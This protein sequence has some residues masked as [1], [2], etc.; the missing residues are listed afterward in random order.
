MLQAKYRG[1][2]RTDVTFV[3]VPIVSRTKTISISEP[4][5]V[6]FALYNTQVVHTCKKQKIQTSKVHISEKFIVR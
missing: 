5:Q 3:S 4:E 1:L 6:M 2:R